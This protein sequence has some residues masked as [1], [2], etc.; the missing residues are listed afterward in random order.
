M[1]QVQN[2]TSVSLKPVN[3]TVAT[4]PDQIHMFNE[5]K[6]YGWSF[7][8]PIMITSDG[9]A[10][11][12][13]V[14]PQIIEN[15]PNAKTTG[16]FVNTQTGWT[17]RLQPEKSVTVYGTQDGGRSWSQLAIVPVKYGDGSMFIAF[18]DTRHGW[19]EEMTAGH[20]KLSGELLATSNGGKTWQRMAS[21]NQ[22]SGLSFDGL[23]TAQ[24]NGTLWLS[25]GQGFQGGSGCN[26]LYK[27]TNGGKTWSQAIL[28]LSAIHQKETTPI[29]GPVFFDKKGIVIAHSIIYTSHDGGQTWL[30]QNTLPLALRGIG[31][32]YDFINKRQGWVMDNGNGTEPSGKVLVLYVTHDD[33]RSWR[34]IL[35]NMSLENKYITEIDFVNSKVGWMLYNYNTEAGPKSVISK[36]INGGRSWEKIK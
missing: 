9:G 33:G 32:V 27:S 22:Q 7:D 2:E 5:Q 3:S 31:A 34:K 14:T 35:T 25:G 8:H 6:G 20:A 30:V 19:F 24:K 10:T 13:D 11:W 4:A 1:G 16:Y 23:L 12:T 28:P 29:Y 15:G 26:W 18:S 21:S 36:S 17:F